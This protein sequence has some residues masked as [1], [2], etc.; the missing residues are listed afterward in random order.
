MSETSKYVLI[1]GV[2]QP[3]EA[4]DALLEV[5]TGKIRFHQQKNLSSMER[6]GKEDEIALRRIPE[7]KAELKRIQQV[8][9]EAE[10][11]QMKLRIH[12]DVH[13]SLSNE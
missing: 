8:V 13:I 11:H 10:A 1:E 2:F 12:A 4:R 7:L 3:Q 5:F 6:F 9:Q